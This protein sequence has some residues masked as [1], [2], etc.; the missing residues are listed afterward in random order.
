MSADVTNLRQGDRVKLAARVVSLHGAGR[1]RPFQSVGLQ[2]AD[3]QHLIVN[4]GNIEAPERS[5]D[6]ET[7]TDE[8][9]AAAVAGGDA[10][11]AVASVS[12]RDVPGPTDAR[13]R[14]RPRSS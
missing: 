11:P 6:P 9:I 4:V 7:M 5:A 12:T 14:G 3:G 8:E 13:R 2:L 10:L 1:A